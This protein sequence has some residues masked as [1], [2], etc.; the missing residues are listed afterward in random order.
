MQ[1]RD[2]SLDNPIRAIREIS[3]DLTGRRQVRLAGGREASALEIQREYHARAVQHIESTDAGPLM[4]HV[5]DL[6]GRALDAV[7]QQDFSLI[8]T[9]IDWGRFC[10]RTRFGPSTSGST[11]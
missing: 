4:R 9:E 6:W 11:V 3:H 8:D 2:F 10:A 1:F 7:E 5:V